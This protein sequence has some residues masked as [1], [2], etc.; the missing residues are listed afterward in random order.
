[1]A[2][3]AIVGVGAI[4]GVLAG[5]VEAAGGHELTLC[6]RRP[7]AELTVETPEGPVR[8]RA[9]NATD[10]SQTNSVDWILC[11]VKT[12]DAAVAAKWFPGL[13]GP[14]TRLAVIQNGVEHREN[15]AGLFPPERILPVVIDVPAERRPDGSVLQRADAVMRVPAGADGSAFAALFAGTRASIELTDDFLSAVWR[16]LCLNS[17]GVIS[18]LTLKPAGV[19]RDEAL[20]E[21]ALGIIAECVAVGRA[22]GAVIDDGIGAQILATTRAGSPDSIN[23][24]LADRL[25]HRQTEIGARNGVIVRRGEKHG[26]PTPLNRMAVALFHGMTS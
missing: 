5:L 13:R 2:R 22:E 9:Q 23:S 7:L 1:M 20:G 3:I 10:V 17:Q 26:I 11:S 16:K 15:F 25:A 19:V 24:L 18:A 21:L 12:Y 6:T 14:E 8:V 4:G